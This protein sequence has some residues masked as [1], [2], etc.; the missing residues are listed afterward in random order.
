MASRISDCARVDC[1]EELHVN[2]VGV[3]PELIRWARRRSGHDDTYMHKRFPELPDWESGRSGPTT[4]KLEKFAKATHT[5]IGYLFLS[6]PPEERLPISDFRTIGDV[7][8]RSPS[9]AMLDTIYLCQQRQAWYRGEIRSAGHEPLDFVDST[10][11]TLDH[12]VVAERMRSRLEFD[13]TRRGQGSWTDAL[14]LLIKKIEESGILVM[15]SGVVGNNPKWSL[16]VNELRGF[17]LTDRWAPLIF[18]NGQDS[19]AAQMFTLAHELA[20]IWLGRSGISN[21]LLSEP[22]THPIETWCNGIAAEL[23]VPSSMMR[24]EYDEGAD[25]SSEME[26]LARL[27]KVSTIV[28]LRRIFDIGGVDKAEFYDIYENQLRAWRRSKPKGGKAHSTMI[29]RTS[30]RFAKLLVASTMEGKTTRT[31]AMRL[32]SIKRIETFNAIAQELGVG[33]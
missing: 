13:A 2:R 16:D 3:K 17:A 19:K 33:R 12:A 18:V 24:S 31:R 32:L 29:R 20:H 22:S 9:A 4:S 6:E 11:I 8:V 23:L 1:T 7:P 28:I 10:D 15:I 25:L 14:N 5:P 27:F 21:Y 30:R 26:R